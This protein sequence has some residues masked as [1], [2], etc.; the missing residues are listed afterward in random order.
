MTRVSVSL[1]AAVG[2]ITLTACVRVKEP[3][4]RPTVAPH[5]ATLW[6]DPGNLQ[7]RDLLNGPWGVER[8][9]RADATYTFVE[10]KHAGV[11]PGMTVVD[12]QGR[13]WSV[14]QIPPGALDVEAQVEVALSRVLSAV[15]YHQPPVYFLPAF[16]LKDDWGRH[17]EVGGRFRL[18][19][20]TL[21]EVGPWAWPENP[22]IGSRPYNGLLVLM[23]MFNSTDLKDS[24]NSIYEYRR[25]DHVEQWFAVRDIGSA[26]GDTNRLGPYKSDP[27][28]FEREPFVLG[29]TNNYV[30]FAYRGYYERYVRNRIRPV[31]VAWAS[32]LLG[33][34]TDKQWNDAFQASG[35]DQQTAASFIRRLQEK[36]REGQA[37]PGRVRSGN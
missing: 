8:A 7:T 34:L 11:N 26:L 29:V 19:D 12:P 16:T 33:E 18:K 28:A 17:T 37:L 3:A 24:N 21:K 25:G 5:G 22:F 14:K 27:D 13:E 36:I 1:A 6:V 32:R 30:Q 9:P 15:G 4:V 10:R 20:M 2:V 35:Y 23:M 31:D